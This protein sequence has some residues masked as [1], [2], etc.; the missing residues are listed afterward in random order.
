MTTTLVA[1]DGYWRGLA[2]G[3]LLAL[4]LLALVYRKWK[5]CADAL[6]ATNASASSANA[7]DAKAPTLG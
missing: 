5:Q 4:P 7:N 1:S 3:L 6:A 2:H